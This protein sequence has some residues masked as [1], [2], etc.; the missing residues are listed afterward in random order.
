MAKKGIRRHLTRNRSIAL[1]IIL[2]SFSLVG[3]GIVDI[4]IDLFQ[5]GAFQGTDFSITVFDNIIPL[6]LVDNFAVQCSLWQEGDIVA[7]DGSIRDIGF[8]TAVFRPQ[9]SLDIIDATT[10]KPLERVTTQIRLRCHETLTGGVESFT[11]TGGTLR[12]QWLVEDKSSN[13]PFGSVLIGSPQ[14]VSITSSNNVLQSPTG[15]G[16]ALAFRNIQE[17]TIDNALT[18]PDLSYL[19][20][21][22]Q[23]ITAELEFTFK[24]PG[25]P[26][27]SQTKTV[28]LIADVGA[29]QGQRF[30]R[31]V[32]ENPDP[33][34]PTNNF[35]NI[36]SLNT[37]PNPMFDN[38]PSPQFRV[39]ISLPEYQTGESAPRVDI[40]KPSG[41]SNIAFLTNVPVTVRSGSNF[42]ATID[43]KQSDLVAGTYV[44][45]AEHQTRTDTDAK[46]FAVYQAST[47]PNEPVDTCEGLT[48]QQ[49]QTLI[50]QQT[51]PCQGLTG[52][53][54]N[55]C[56]G[57][58]EQFSGCANGFTSRTTSQLNSLI[59]NLPQGATISLQSGF[60]LSDNPT[61]V[62]NTT[63][64]A[65]QS[66]QE[67]EGQNCPSQFPVRVSS[68]EF[69]QITQAIGQPADATTIGETD[70]CI[71]IETRDLF[72]QSGGEIDDGTGILSAEAIMLY[73][74]IYD[75]ADEVGN[76][77]NLQKQ[78]ITF[79]PLQLAGI[80][81]GLT[82]VYE[83]KRLIV[84]PVIDV[85]DL[86][87]ATIS[88]PDFTFLWTAELT[89]QGSADPTQTVTLE[90][91][92]NSCSKLDMSTVGIITGGGNLGFKFESEV[93]ET[94]V[95]I[96][97][98]Q[99]G[100]FYQIARSDI[101]PN[102]LVKALDDAGIKPNAGDEVEVTVSVEG[103]F[104]AQVG[105]QTG[106]INE[107]GVITPMTFTHVFNWIPNFGADDEPC[108]GLVG[109]AQLQCEG[110]PFDAGGYCE[111]LT[112]E[113]CSQKIT[114]D[115]ADKEKDENGCKPTVVGTKV[116]QLCYGDEQEKEDS[117]SN[118]DGSLGSN[119]KDKSS[120][121]AGLVNSCPEGTPL[122]ECVN[123][124]LR[125]LEQKLSSF[126]GLGGGTIT[127][128]SNNAVLIIG[129]VIAI[130]VVALVLQRVA[131]RNRQRKLGRSL[132]G[133]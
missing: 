64:A 90:E 23:L 118:N 59:E 98:I 129:A 57:I 83:F 9:F 82:Q 79:N 5:G 25:S 106:V 80:P 61:C 109:L 22:K 65:A 108:S 103:T 84:N 16:I 115:G 55:T 96:K 126:L 114:R 88:S 72:L 132:L 99:G 49:C 40:F 35:V 87:S 31:V 50:N 120:G 48:Q 6:S 18:S 3:L 76:I 54:L 93:S 68:D 133:L 77:Q 17:A 29:T 46:P 75:G 92:K 111:E 128:L 105:T 101:Q 56:L 104:T 78:S 41:S 130:I 85:T 20:E 123:L 39:E 51:D 131:A 11:L 60:T 36:V 127:T 110:N 33:P 71:S 19:V 2:I 53:S 66:N 117:G 102:Q 91:C 86:G 70:F 81:T 44:V 124:T 34:A 10:D 125:T 28:V 13:P 63:I 43:I 116:I 14:V 58:V 27:Q 52:E 7:T 30:L 113:Q 100:R 42:V 32:N 38:D 89:P 26:T 4:G 24:S 121:T 97:E 67:V 122:S 12:T 62:S 21:L 45:Q 107:Q 94:D 15:S 119:D 8:S 74:V 1:V 95:V 69:Q 73:Q 112:P 47:Q 37:I